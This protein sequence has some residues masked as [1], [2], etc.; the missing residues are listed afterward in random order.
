[1]VGEQPVKLIKGGNGCGHK[2]IFTMCMANDPEARLRFRE[3]KEGE[4]LQDMQKEYQEN[5]AVTA[6]HVSMVLAILIRMGFLN[7]SSIYQAWSSADG[8]SLSD[9]TIREA[10]PRNKFEKIW[11]RLAFMD[12]KNAK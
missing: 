2:N 9:K 1:M 3:R 11:S 10:M 5:E 8:G 4:T 6:D 7:H 12:Y